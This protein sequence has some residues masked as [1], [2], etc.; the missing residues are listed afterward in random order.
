MG[1]VVAVHALHATVSLAWRTWVFAEPVTGCASM[2][3]AEAIYAQHTHT[4]MCQARCRVRPVQ[5]FAS[6]AASRFLGTRAASL[7]AW[8]LPV[9]CYSAYLADRRTP[10]HWPKS[11]LR[12]RTSCRLCA[13]VHMYM[14]GSAQVHCCTCKTCT[15][16]IRR[17]EGVDS[18][19]ACHRQQSTRFATL[20]SVQGH[21]LHRQQLARRS[22]AS[23]A[24]HK[25]EPDQVRPSRMAEIQR[26]LVRVAVLSALLCCIRSGCADCVLGHN[27]G[28]LLQPTTH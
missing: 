13:L 12:F 22:T 5:I 24:H 3:M 16:N 11:M 2:V 25:Q 8:M 18:N 4:R 21:L 1:E 23:A 14:C 17:P 28:A 26:R 7:F 9:I 6:R 15:R 10:L 19:P 27:A 20:E